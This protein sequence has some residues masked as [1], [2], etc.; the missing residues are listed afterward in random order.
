MLN[1]LI[2]AGSKDKSQTLSTKSVKQKSEPTS[3]VDKII[4][5]RRLQGSIAEFVPPEQAASKF[6]R[7]GKSRAPTKATTSRERIPTP[8]NSSEESD[9]DGNNST[10]NEAFIPAE[11]IEQDAKKREVK[12]HQTFA[13]TIDKEIS[14]EI[15]DNNALVNIRKENLLD[16][17]LEGPEE[18]AILAQVEINIPEVGG[19]E[20]PNLLE[21]IE[22]LGNATGEG[23]AQ[24]PK[25]KLPSPFFG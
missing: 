19:V 21:K 13:D 16:L 24:G 8:H 2:L 14:E 25:I 10:L 15:T 23:M 7:S 5:S 22:E 17:Q 18:I 20:F 12:L 6:W 1:A 3:L 4:I 11:N 9:S